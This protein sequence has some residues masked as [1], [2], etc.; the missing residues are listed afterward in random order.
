MKELGYRSTQHLAHSMGVHRN[1]LS[2]YLSGAAVLPKHLERMLVLLRLPI[3]RALVRV[4]DPGDQLSDRITGLVDRLFAQFPQVSFVLFGSRARNTQSRYSD[5][6]LGV[7]A[8]QGIAHAD[9]RSMRIA[10][11]E[12]ADNLPVTVDLVNLNR[13][14]REFLSRVVQDGRLLAGKQ[15]DWL[16]LQERAQDG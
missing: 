5:I 16:A 12:L 7:Y 11:A 2:N 14:D 6:D 15:S 1:T 10:L 3:E 13:A 4:D 9:Y 8:R